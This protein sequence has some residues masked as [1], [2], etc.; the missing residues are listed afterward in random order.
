MK[1]SIM[2]FILLHNYNYI[3]IINFFS[4]KININNKLYIPVINK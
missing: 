3:I 1:L 4:D 2:S